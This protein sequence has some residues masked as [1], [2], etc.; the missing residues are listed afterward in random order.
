MLYLINI[1][2]QRRTAEQGRAQTGTVRY[3]I[4]ARSLGAAKT[5]ASRMFNRHMGTLLAITELQEFQDPAGLFEGSACVPP[6]S[7]F[8]DCGSGH[9][10]G[11][12]PQCGKG[13]GQVLLENGQQLAV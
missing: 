7:Y 11:V 4:N 2:W 13:H 10:Y 5:K 9:H 12:C 8:R 1:H 3:T 6:A